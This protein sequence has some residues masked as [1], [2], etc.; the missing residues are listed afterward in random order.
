M[1]VWASKDEVREEVA[2]VPENWLMRFV[3]HQPGDVRKFAD[4]S[5][6]KV[7]YRVSAVLDAIE[8]GLYV[9]ER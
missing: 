3:Q 1:R 6:G 8:N 2:S 5:N 7:L 4:T 9:R